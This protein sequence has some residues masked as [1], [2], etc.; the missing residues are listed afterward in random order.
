MSET[1]GPQG[2]MRNR[3]ASAPLDDIDAEIL[4]GI[5]TLFTA[6]DPPP[7]HLVDRIQFALELEDA[8]VEVLR[9]E[10]DRDLVAATRGEQSRT[11]TFDSDSMSIMIRISPG[12]HGRIRL[13]GWLAPPAARQVE[14]RCTGRS[15]HTDADDQGRFVFEEVRHGLVQL[16]VHLMEDI[17]PIDGYAAEAAGDGAPARRR[18]VVTPSIE[19]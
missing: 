4:D 2:A 13:D 19:V 10:L 18:L 12:E 5:R 11:V 16:T 14:L 9:L 6:T 3:E 1:G 8:D 7:R 15:L 17:A